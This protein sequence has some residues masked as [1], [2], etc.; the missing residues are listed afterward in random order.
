[1][2][3]GPA[4]CIR[5]VS[6]RICLVELSRL[7]SSVERISSTFVNNKSALHVA[8]RNERFPTFGLG[9]FF[10]T[11][12]EKESEDD[13]GSDVEKDGDISVKVSFPLRDPDAVKGTTKGNSKGGSSDMSVEDGIDRSLY[14]HEVKMKM[15]DMGSDDDPVGKVAKWYKKEGDL[16]H[17]KDTLCDIELE[18]S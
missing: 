4:A 5:L 13:A 1:M 15:P 18:V 3:Q 12:S 7:H 9:K 8:R 2:S 6:Q 11:K 17:R 10:S 14:V 16:I